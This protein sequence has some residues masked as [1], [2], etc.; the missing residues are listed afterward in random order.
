MIQYVLNAAGCRAPRIR[1]NVQYRIIWGLFNAKSCDYIQIWLYGGIRIFSVT[2]RCK[3][4][5]F[6]TKL[7]VSE[8][9]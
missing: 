8:N 7:E 1:F 2:C 3:A 4:S 9:S 6:D 5:R